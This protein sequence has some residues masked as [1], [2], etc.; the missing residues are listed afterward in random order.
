MDLQGWPK[1]PQK[2]KMW[3]QSSEP[4]I[5]KKYWMFGNIENYKSK[6]SQTLLYCLS[7]LPISVDYQTLARLKI[8]WTCQIL[9]LASL[10]PTHFLL[11]T[12][13]ISTLEVLSFLHSSSWSSRQQCDLSL[14]FLSYFVTFRLLFSDLLGPSDSISLYFLLFPMVLGCKFKMFGR[15]I[16]N[17]I[18]RFSNNKNSIK[19]VKMK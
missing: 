9:N 1:T 6:H 3:F 19:F 7:H 4:L 2:L 15:Y 18:F 14:Y 12:I 5:V 10:P 16:F 11:F 8:D 13:G 17:S